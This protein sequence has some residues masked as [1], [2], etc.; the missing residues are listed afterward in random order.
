VVFIPL[1]G[2]KCFTG[3]IRPAGCRLEAPVLEW[4]MR[5]K[6][7]L[8]LLPYW[9]CVLSSVADW[10]ELPRIL[11]CTAAG[12]PTA[13]G[14]DA[15]RSLVRSANRWGGTFWIFSLIQWFVSRSFRIRIFGH[16]IAYGFTKM[17]FNLKFDFKL[18]RFKRYATWTTG[19]RKNKTRFCEH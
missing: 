14:C 12:K 8:Q 19:R 5:A 13:E 7:G 15:H 18:G 2:W 1:V 9:K 4:L 16:N 11:L 3:R 6:I 10:L 17:S